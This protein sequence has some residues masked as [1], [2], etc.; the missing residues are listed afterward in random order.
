MSEVR[1]EEVVGRMMAATGTASMRALAP[2]LGLSSHT[3]IS[4]AK[5]KNALPKRWLTTM[6]FQHGINPE[7]LLRGEGEMRLSPPR[8]QSGSSQTA[9]EFLAESLQSPENIQPALGYLGLVLPPCYY[10]WLDES[11][12]PVINLNTA[13]GLAI[14]KDSPFFSGL[15]VEHLAILVMPN[16]DMEP[17]I[18]KKDIVYVDRQDTMLAHDFMYCIAVGRSLLI[19]RYVEDRSEFIAEREGVRPIPAAGVAVFGK[20]VAMMRV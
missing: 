13:P 9:L 19:R 8:G 3:P 12:K 15:S 11:G 2:L 5:A 18:Q 20:V 17:E 1:V 10:P 14:P 6:E 16:R 7:W 4:V